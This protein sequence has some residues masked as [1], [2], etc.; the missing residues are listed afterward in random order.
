MYI[1]WSVKCVFDTYIFWVFPTKQFS[2]KGM[3]RIPK[4]FR[5]D[6]ANFHGLQIIHFVVIGIIGY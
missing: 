2:V 6:C 5:K 3:G 1:V 4:Y